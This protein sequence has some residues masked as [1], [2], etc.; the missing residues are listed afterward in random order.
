M[1]ANNRGFSIARVN[2]ISVEVTADVSDIAIGTYLI[3]SVPS[4]ILFDFGASHSFIS[5]RYASTHDL[6]YISMRKPMV[7]ITPKRPIE[8]NFTCCQ[9]KITILGRNFWSTPIVLEESD[10]DLILGTKWLKECNVVIHYAKGTVELTSPDG[11]RF[12]VAVTLSP[13]TKPTIY[14]LDGKFVGDHILV[15]RD[16]PDV[17]PEELP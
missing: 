3:N 17:F 2:Q 6:P 5:A 9:N 14:L 4:S 10:I 8:S 1:P 12:E 11:D 16:F 13:S 15:V 7:V